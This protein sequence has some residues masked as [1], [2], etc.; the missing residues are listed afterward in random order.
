MELIIKSKNVELAPSLKS[1]IVQKLDKINRHLP[2]ILEFNLE[3]TEEKTKS[4]ENRFVAQLT[5]DNNGNILRAEER[6]GD[7]LTVVDRV[8]ETIMRRIERYKGKFR[9]RVRGSETI[10]TGFDEGAPAEPVKKIVRVKHFAVKPIS[11]TDA[12][13]QMELLGHDFFLFTNSETAE[14][15][16]VY[17]RRDGNYGLIEPEY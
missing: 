13:E 12:I 11:V 7:L 5:V 1:H 15:N 17:R 4:P 9:E 6:G 3:L 2:K 16:L 10:R 14:A 8:E